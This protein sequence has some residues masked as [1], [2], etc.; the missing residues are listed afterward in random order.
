MLDAKCIKV[1]REQ[2]RLSQSSLAVAIGVD[3]QYV[4]K[5]EHGVRTDIRASTLGKLADALHC[6][7]DEL[8]GRKRRAAA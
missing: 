5:L 2:R 4:W 7:T 1:L 6:T 8:L 3:R